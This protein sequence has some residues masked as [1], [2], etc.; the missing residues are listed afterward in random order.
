[1]SVEFSEAS[2][3]LLAPEA[4]ID[5][6]L[7]GADPTPALAAAGAIV[8]GAPHPSL[9][10]ALQAVEQALCRMRLERGERT[11]AVWA[12][13]A[14]CAILVPQEGRLRLSSFPTLF[15]PDALARVNDLGPR[16]RIEPARTIAIAPGDLANAIATRSAAG[17]GLPED[18]RELLQ[19]TLDG[20]RE[21][22]RVEARWEPSPESP[23][24]RVVEVVDTDAGMWSVIPDGSRVELWP[25]TPTKVFRALGGLLPRD[26]EIGVPS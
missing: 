18:E 14:V 7:A 21:H 25:T 9:E 3:T 17:A 2:G 12:S 11:G 19:T 6:L 10:P 1:V 16:P 23:G 13:P 20:L 15:L 8:D 4:V 26:H 24:V 22:W 5:G